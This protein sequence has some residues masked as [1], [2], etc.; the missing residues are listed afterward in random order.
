[1]NSEVS[2][3]S[4]P[5]RNLLDEREYVG[6]E[7]IS[8]PIVALSGIHDVGY[9]ELV[10]IIDDDTRGFAWCGRGAGLRGYIGS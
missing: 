4:D 1:M 2:S 3:D 6:I 7:E 8:G 5:N 9:N 10:E